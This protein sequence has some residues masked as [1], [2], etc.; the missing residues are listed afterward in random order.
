ML[1]TISASKTCSFL[2]RC[3]RTALTCERVGDDDQ[4]SHDRGQT[5]EGVVEQVPPACVP[6]VVQDAIE[7]HVFLLL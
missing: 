1:V 2:R 4:A 3:T 7:L 6:Y 5:E